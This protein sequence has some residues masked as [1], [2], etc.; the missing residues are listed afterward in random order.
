MYPRLDSYQNLI[1]SPRDAEDKIAGGRRWDDEPRQVEE[2]GKAP[3]A[4]Q[5]EEDWPTRL[6]RNEQ[7][8]RRR[9]AEGESYEDQAD[10]AIFPPKH[11][12]KTVKTPKR[13]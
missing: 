7:D 10:N 2:A 3:G 4:D 12:D 11:T 13:P 9:A 1:C 6:R 8:D 5:V